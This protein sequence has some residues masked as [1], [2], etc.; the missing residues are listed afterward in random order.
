MIHRLIIPGI[1]VGALHGGMFLIPNPP[2]PPPAKAGPARPVEVIIL[3]KIPVI[4][5]DDPARAQS[6]DRPD[7]RPIPVVQEVPSLHVTSE[8]T[9]PWVPE[10]PH[11]DIDTKAMSAGLGDY[12]QRGIGPGGGGEFKDLIDFTKLDKTPG[13]VFQMAPEYP[14]EAKRNG[15]TGEVT[16]TFTVD[17]NGE[18]H[19]ARVA[20]TT[21]DMFNEAAIRA[22][23]R[24]RFEPGRFHG[25]R[26]A[27]RMSVPIAFTLNDVE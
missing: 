1:I 9:T 2:L 25:K 3:P 20:S 7:V 16:V 27:F 19:G 23:S 11:V 15:M 10:L 13:T 12:L 8:W 17:E 22:V 18:V 6:E 26:V 5:T 4:L 14:P 21:H 24:W